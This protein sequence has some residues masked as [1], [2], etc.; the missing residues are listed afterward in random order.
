MLT[1]SGQST[2]KLRRY[3]WSQQNKARTLGMERVKGR[4]FTEK[5][6]KEKEKEEK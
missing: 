3:G 4:K 6:E 1:S 5:K 2:I